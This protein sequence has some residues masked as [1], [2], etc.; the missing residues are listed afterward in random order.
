M[1]HVMALRASGRLKVRVTMGP[2]RVTST[3][4]LASGVFTEGASWACDGG[5]GVRVGSPGV[6]RPGHRPAG[7]VAVLGAWALLEPLDEAGFDLSLREI[8]VLA[9]EPLTHHLHPGLE[10]GESETEPGRGGLR[11]RT[12]EI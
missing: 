10:E 4:L 3:S 8:R 2:S 1:P 7:R 5:A 6:P 12:P 9:P 11:G